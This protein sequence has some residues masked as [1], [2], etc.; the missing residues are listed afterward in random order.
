MMGELVATLIRRYLALLAISVAPVGFGVIAATHLDICDVA[1]QAGILPYPGPLAAFRLIVPQR[2][3]QA[4]QDIAA[5]DTSSSIPKEGQPKLASLITQTP[6]RNVRS[7][8]FQAGER[9][10]AGSSRT[11]GDATTADDPAQSS[12][13]WWFLL[14][15]LVLLVVLWLVIMLIVRLVALSRARLGGHVA[16]AR[17]ASDSIEPTGAAGA[18]EEATGI[19]SPDVTASNRL[20]QG[21]RLKLKLLRES[22]MIRIG[23]VL[24]G[25]FGPRPPISDLSLPPMSVRSASMELCLVGI[26]I[27]LFSLPFLDFSPDRLLPGREFDVVAFLDF[28]MANSLRRFG[29]F[30]TWNFQLGTGQPLIGDPFMHMFNP[31]SSVPVLLFGVVNGFKIA[32]FASLMIAAF[33]QWFLGRVIGLNRPTRVWAAVIFALNGQAV[34]RFI[35]GEYL[36]TFGL[37]WIPL[38]FGGIVLS[39]RTRRP[40]YYILTAVAIT[41]MFFSGNGYYTYYAAVILGLLALGVGL[42]TTRRWEPRWSMVRAGPLLIIGALAIGLTAVQ[43][44]PTIELWQYIQKAGDPELATSQSLLEVLNDYAFPST[45]RPIAQKNL[46]PEEFY[47]YIGIFPLLAASLALPAF[48]RGWRRREILSL[49]ALVALTIVW[50]C[51]RYTPLAPIYRTTPPLIIL[52]YPSRMMV[53]GTVALVTLAGLGMTWLMETR[54]RSSENALED[55]DGAHRSP[56]RFLGGLLTLA[57]GLSGINIF[58]VKQRL[59]GTRERT[60]EADAVLSWLTAYDPRPSHVSIPAT[61]G[62]HLAVVA[63]GERYWDVWYGYDFFPPGENRSSQRPIE[64]RPNYLVLEQDALPPEG[65]IAA[66]AR[67]G[68]QTVYSLED[69]LPFAFAVSG[70]ILSGVNQGAVERSE[71]IELQPIE[72][73]PDEIS[74]RAEL[75]DARSWVVLLTS[76]FPGWHVYVDGQPAELV[77]MGNYLSVQGSPGSREYTF[78]YESASFRAGLAVTSATVLLLMGLLLRYVYSQST[79]HGIR[80]GRQDPA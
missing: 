41:L 3:S 22:D 75:T 34:A 18:P 11:Y 10:K 79:A 6:V 33:G 37:A 48:W 2:V 8:V 35:Q 64:A 62:W 31:I 5:T 28:V 67:I 68:N 50:I 43:W 38:T 13:S 42:H 24:R 55:S 16:G 71:V 76:Y 29:V 21:S 4:E 20:G 19:R 69:S 1:V 78:R 17:P 77:P 56:A 12:R 74:V 59:V 27:L 80:R 72:G 39:L 57:M 58:L 63:S 23:Q 46:P 51:I 66:I 49:T 54:R 7:E 47:G 15:P 36:F 45:D 44:A 65:N 52:R 61:E 32:V 30:P 26:V 60:H 73:G 14:L 9:N 40:R 25:R 53:Y 70:S